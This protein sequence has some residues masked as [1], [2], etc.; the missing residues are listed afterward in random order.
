MFIFKRPKT[1]K[2]F[3]GQTDFALLNLKWAARWSYKR[4]GKRWSYKNELSY[5]QGKKLKCMSVVGMSFPFGCKIQL[6]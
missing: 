6:P 2:F 4:K 3:F 5:L 1:E